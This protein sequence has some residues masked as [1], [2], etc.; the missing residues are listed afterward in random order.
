MSSR[1]A[2]EP[3]DQAMISITHSYG[4][5]CPISGSTNSGSNSCPYAVISVKNST[6]NATIVNQCATATSGSRDIRVCPRNSR[7]NVVVR[8]AGWSVR[9][10]GGPAGTLPGTG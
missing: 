7:T 4:G 3:A 1:I 8:A 10:S 5:Q 2:D 9:T 6:P